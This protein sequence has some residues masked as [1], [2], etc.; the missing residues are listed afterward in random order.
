RVAVVAVPPGRRTLGVA[1]VWHDLDLVTDLDRRLTLAFGIAIPI[2]AAFAVVAGSAVAARGLRPLVAMAE[3]ASEIEAHD[4][5]R[6]IAIPLRDDELGR[7]VATFDRML[8]RLQSAFERQRRFTGDA[9]HELR[10][11]LSVIRAEADLMLRRPRSGDEYRRALEAIAVQADDLE[12]LTR[13]LLAAA[14][15][16]SAPAES[17]DVVDLAVIAGEAADRLAV[18]A[19]S[20]GIALARSL[21]PGALIRGDGDA[22]RRATVC[23]LHNALK[24]GRHEGTVT[25]AVEADE[26]RV[27]LVVADDGPGFSDAALDHATERFWRDDPARGRADGNG[28]ASGSGLG[29]SIAAAIVQS[30]GGTLTL[31]NRRE[32]GASAVVELPSAGPFIRG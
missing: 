17:G 26:N 11:P 5:S 21:P 7:L 18:L 13:D 2:I 9:S 6:R 14:R 25:V 23:L 32:G 8:D 28:E 27:R 31:T 4:L 20:R 29:L 19:G 10:A 30:A 12:A 15:A 24:Y 22:L 16:E 1:F 3:I